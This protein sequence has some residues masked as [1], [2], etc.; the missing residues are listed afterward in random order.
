MRGEFVQQILK[1]VTQDEIAE[2]V[3]A[4]SSAT[5]SLHTNNA[6]TFA[7]IVSRPTSGGQGVS[8][9]GFSQESGP[10]VPD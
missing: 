7:S 1:G 9:A 10:L 5:R 8:P 6:T 3:S 2:V 4:R